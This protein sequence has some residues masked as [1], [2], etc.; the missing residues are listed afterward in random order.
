MVTVMGIKGMEGLGLRVFNFVL[1]G[2]FCCLGFSGIFFCCLGRGAGPARTAKKKKRPRPF[3][4]CFV[5]LFVRVGVFIVFL[6]GREGGGC[7]FFCCLGGVHVVFAVWAGACRL[8]CCLGGGGGRG[9]GCLFFLLFERER[10][11]FAVWPLF[12]FCCLGGAPEF[13]HLPVC[14]ALSQATQQQKRP[15]SKK[16]KGSEGLGLP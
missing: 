12:F 3:R 5:L 16:K 2:L 6:F 1:S 9:G 8:F 13:I 11:F 4:A 15:N 14:L 10:V 7:V